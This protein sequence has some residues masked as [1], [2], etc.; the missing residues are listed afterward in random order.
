MERYEQ[1]KVL[2]RGSYGSAVLVRERSG[3][4][5]KFVVKEVELSKM[6]PAAKKEAE[7]E[8]QVLQCCDHPN[9]VRYVDTFLHGAAKLCILME[10]A[11]GGDLSGAVKAQQ[12]KGAPFPE[13]EVLRTFAQCCRALRHCHKKH[14]LHR[15]LKC[16]NIFLTSNGSVKV[17]DFGISK[18]LDHT[19]AV[20]VTMIGT[21]LYLAPEVCQSMPYGVKADIWSLGVV[22]HELLALSV[23]FQAENMAALVVKI[24][25]Q[26]PRK[27]PAEACGEELRRLLAR[28]LEKPPE[29]RPSCLLRGP[30]QQPPRPPPPRQRLSRALYPSTGDDFS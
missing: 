13:A 2:G 3:E 24:I 15:D 12:Q 29:R 11:D 23:P 4:R 6:G 20:A 21:P 10:Y 1:L 30:W 17:G 27:V 22:L 19:G 25:N 14:I 16:G 9:I 7:K 18:V 26:P 8:V 28:M 5:R